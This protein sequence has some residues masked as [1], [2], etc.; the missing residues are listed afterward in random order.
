MMLETVAHILRRRRTQG[1]L[2]GGTVRDRE[3]GGGSPDLDVVVADDP[4]AV[5]R[6]IA[7]R[8]DSPWFALSARHGAYRVIGT[9]G[10]VDVAGMRGKGILDDLAQRDF[11]INAMAIAVDASRGAGDRIDPFGGWTHLREKRLVAVSD[12]VFIDDPLRLMR[13]ARFCHVLGLHLDPS[14]EV[15]LRSQAAVLLRAAPERVATEMALTLSGGFSAGAFRLWAELGLLEHI[16]PEVVSSWAAGGAARPLSGSTAAKTVSVEV[17]LARLDHSL[18]HLSA[19]FPQ[20]ASVLSERLAAPVDGA[21]TRPVALRLAAMTHS[22]A[23]EEAA[24]AARRLRLSADMLSL[25][26]KVSACFRGGRCSVEALQRAVRGAARSQ[27]LFLWEAAPWEPESILLAASAGKAPEGATNASGVVTRGGAPVTTDDI[28]QTALAPDLA[29]RLPAPEVLEPARRL[30]D[31]W[32][33]RSLRP[34]PALPVD[35]EILMREFGLVA[36]PRLGEIL[37]EVRLA[38]EAGE[39]TTAGEA[40]RV[41]EGLLEKP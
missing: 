13:A 33:D 38:W 12:R 34:R 28:A 7:G 11:T 32:G 23:P 20:S 40:M 22:L 1:W 35:G 19:W 29:G 18:D 4:A 17:T 14:L 6:E 5:A 25:L 37:R 10:H 8:L 26:R 39:A 31:R 21:W 16:L 3:S 36:G 41:A 27:V 30:M 24:A 2:V 15:L 9:E